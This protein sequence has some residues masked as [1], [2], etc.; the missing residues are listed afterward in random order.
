MTRKYWILVFLSIGIVFLDQWTKSV[1]LA[2][3]QLGNLLAIA[4]QCGNDAFGGLGFVTEEFRRTEL[5]AKREPD[6][7]GRG[8]AGA[9]ARGAADS[10]ARRRSG[11]RARR[12]V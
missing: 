6:R 5:L 9:E 1:I 11:C 10:A 3:F 4:H 2:R 7:G 12:Q 8:L